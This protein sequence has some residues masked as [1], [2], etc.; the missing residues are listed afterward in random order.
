MS[1]LQRPADD[2]GGRG[3]GCDSRLLGAVAHDT[4]PPCSML[5]QRPT[6]RGTLLTYPRIQAWI[7]DLEID[8]I[9]VQNHATF[10]A[11]GHPPAAARASSRPSSFLPYSLPPAARWKLTPGLPPPPYPSVESGDIVDATASLVDAVVAVR[12]DLASP[13]PATLIHTA[14]S[15]PIPDSPALTPLS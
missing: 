13:R 6:Y 14:I 4:P 9:L 11:I 5:D 1:L 10:T 8:N 7:A 12:A 2:P 15:L 3:R